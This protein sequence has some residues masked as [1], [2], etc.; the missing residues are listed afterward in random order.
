MMST[1]R[2]TPTY[3]T[4]SQVRV[5]HCGLKSLSLPKSISGKTPVS[6]EE[7]DNCGVKIRSEVC[8]EQ[9]QRKWVNLVQ[10]N[11]GGVESPNP[12]A[13][14]APT[15]EITSEAVANIAR[16]I[17][18]DFLKNVDTG[19]CVAEVETVLREN[20]QPENKPMKFIYE[21]TVECRTCC[22]TYHFPFHLK[23]VLPR[24]RPL[25]TTK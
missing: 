4:P 10:M 18:Q 6:M 9:V 24:I 11:F 20:I 23:V 13:E 2:E 12:T 21:N 16:E 25:Q 15:F 17:T 1:R 3:S 14:E 19:E 22:W 5:T 8:N 7:K